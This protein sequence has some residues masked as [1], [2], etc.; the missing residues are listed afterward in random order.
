MLAATALCSFSVPTVPPAAVLRFYRE[1]NYITNKITGMIESRSLSTA[2]FF[3]DSST[4]CNEDACCLVCYLSSLTL[5]L[6]TFSR[7]SRSS[8]SLFVSEDIEYSPQASPTPSFL[9]V[10]IELALRNIRLTESKFLD[11]WRLHNPNTAA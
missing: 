4:D 5:Q 8:V 2:P 3:V 10:F 11:C 1:H 7:P 9:I 6:P